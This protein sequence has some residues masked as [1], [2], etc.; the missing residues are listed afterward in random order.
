MYKLVVYIP[1]NSLESVKTALFAAGAG[2]LGHY[3]CCAWQTKG[4][5]QFRPLQGS[6]PSIG[7]QNQ[8][9]SLDEWRLEIQVEEALAAEV[10]K[11]LIEAHPYE[12]PAFEFLACVD[13]D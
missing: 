10:K 1:E 11:A 13:V 5:G 3:D 8:L 7:D 4:V 9:E 12:E 2:K 6:N